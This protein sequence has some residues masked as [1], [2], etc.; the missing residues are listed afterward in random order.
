M[1]GGMRNDFSRG[2]SRLKVTEPHR[3]MQAEGNASLTRRD[4]W[5]QDLRKI[6]ALRQARPP[7]RGRLSVC[8]MKQ[9]LPSSRRSRR[10]LR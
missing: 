4:Y 9:F 5:T 2:Q 8:Q 10:L 3:L 1:I 6:S 7:G